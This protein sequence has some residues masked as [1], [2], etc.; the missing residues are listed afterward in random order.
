MWCLGGTVASYNRDS[1]RHQ[2]NGCLLLDTSSRRSYF[3]YVYVF[4]SCSLSILTSWHARRGSLIPQTTKLFADLLAVS[5]PP[6]SSPPFPLSFSGLLCS[7]SSFLLSFL[8]STPHMTCFW[9]PQLGYMTHYDS[10]TFFM[11]LILCFYKNAMWL[12]P[13]LQTFNFGTVLT[14]WTLRTFLVCVYIQSKHFFYS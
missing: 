8:A 12:T 13:Y 2:L 9:V 14:S 4:A 7:T 1:E 6:I 11:A 3:L 10:W 5:L